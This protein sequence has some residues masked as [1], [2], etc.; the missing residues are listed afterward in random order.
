[1]PYIKSNYINNWRINKLKAKKVNHMKLIELDFFKNIIKIDLP[2][3][4]AI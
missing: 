2:S 3:A 4:H 1:M